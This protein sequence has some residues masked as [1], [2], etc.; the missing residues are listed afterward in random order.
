M[1]D[2]S[3]SG[4]CEQGQFPICVAFISFSCFSSLDKMANMMFNSKGFS[5]SQSYKKKDFLLQ[6]L[7][8]LS[9]VYLLLTGEGSSVPSLLGVFN[10]G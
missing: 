4:L 5:G 3:L 7:L 10:Y 6:S 8:A 9:F 2:L 1:F